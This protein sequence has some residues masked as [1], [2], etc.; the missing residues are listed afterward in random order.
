MRE[1]TIFWWPGTLKPGVVMDMGTT[2]DLLPT[3]CSLSHTPLP[4]DRVY[5]GYDISPLLL[6]T[7]SGER[8]CVFYYRG[9]QVYAVRKGHYKAHFITQLEY[10]SETAHPITQPALDIKNT[11]T[12][13]EQP[14]LYNLSVDPGEKYNIAEEHPEVI[15][16]IRSVLAEHLSTLVE[17][18]NQLEK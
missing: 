5:D 18:E 10:N 8:E 11:P 13:L 14:L 15:Q 17:V 9:E 6:G 16:E 1:P 2:M 3:F 4:D 7:G 12:V